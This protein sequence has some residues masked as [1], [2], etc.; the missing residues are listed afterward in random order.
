MADIND[1]AV[2]A[3]S[4]S[5]LVD[6]IKAANLIDTLK[7][8]DSFIASASTDQAFAKLPAGTIETLLENINKIQELLT[9]HVVSG[10]V[11]PIKPIEGS[12]FKMDPF[13]SFN[14]DYNSQA[15]NPMLLMITV[16]STSLLIPR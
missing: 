9:Y 15:Q 6:A 5:T 13:N 11:M 3:G 12:S 14:A 1:R 2:N 8:V 16:S 7:G 10:K 4:F